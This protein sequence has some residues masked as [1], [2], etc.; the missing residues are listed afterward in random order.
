MFSEKKPPIFGGFFYV[1]HGLDQ[2]PVPIS[3][4]HQ[5]LPPFS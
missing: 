2:P 3:S 1:R 4:V 5:I